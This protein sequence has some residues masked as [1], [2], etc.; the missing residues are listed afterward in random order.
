MAAKHIEL[1]D[2]EMDDFEVCIGSTAP[3]P[4]GAAD[5]DT[6]SEETEESDS[7]DAAP[8]PPRAPG[9]GFGFGAPAAPGGFGFGTAKA[10]AATTT[11][12]VVAKA[13]AAKAATGGAEEACAAFGGMMEQLKMAERE[14]A[15]RED[16]FDSGKHAACIKAM[17]PFADDS[18]AFR[19]LRAARELMSEYCALSPQQWGGWVAQEAR[20]AEALPERRYVVELLGRAVGDFPTPEL[21]IE[22]CAQLNALFEQAEEEDAYSAA[23]RPDGDA[24][25][26][27]WVPALTDA[28][29]APWADSGALKPREVLVR[30]A[31][32]AA[33]AAAGHNF[34][35][36]PAVF[37]AY[38]A[39]VEEEEDAVADEEEDKASPAVVQARA[40]YR[41][42]KA[43]VYKRL[44]LVPH[45]GMDDTEGTLRAWLASDDIASRPAT[46]EA[47]KE[48]LAAARVLN[49]TKPLA[50]QCVPYET[51]LRGTQAKRA[52]LKKKMNDAAAAAAAA[53]KELNPNAKAH[54]DAAVL[55]KQEVKEWVAYIEAEELK[56]DAAR[57]RAVA[58]R[59]VAAVPWSGTLWAKYLRLC[60]DAGDH[61]LAYQLAQRAVRS[62][63]RSLT[64]WIAL[65]RSVECARGLSFAT[66]AMPCFARALR[67]TFRAAVESRHLLLEYLSAARRAALIDPALLPDV[68]AETQRILRHA[69]DSA[70]AQKARQQHAALHDAGGAKASAALAHDLTADPAGLQFIARL[71]ATLLAQQHEAEGSKQPAGAVAPL[72]ACYTEALKA[73]SPAASPRLLYVD[74]ADALASAKAAPTKIRDVYE[75]GMAALQE[76]VFPPEEAG[77]LAAAW[78]SFERLHGTHVRVDA[79]RDGHYDAIR[80]HYLQTVPALAADPV[81]AD[82]EAEVDDEGR[83]EDH[84][85]GEDERVSSRKRKRREMD[86]ERKDAKAEYW[87]AHKESLGLAGPQGPQELAAFLWNIPFQCTEEDIKGFLKG[88]EFEGIRLIKGKGGRSKGICYV[89][90]PDEA[91]LETVLKRDKAKLEGRQVRVQRSDPSRSAKGQEE[92]DAQKLQAKRQKKCVLGAVFSTPPPAAAAAGGAPKPAAAAPAAAARGQAFFKNLLSK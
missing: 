8:A 80:K 64:L 73:V 7:E 4:A 13:P 12:T 31:Y 59:G 39:W 34:Q 1:S 24:A 82:A 68:L 92:R 76:G 26:H 43:K 22:L 67:V 30:D 3:A 27:P 45:Y 15:A 74:F 79:V 33:V 28:W 6:A 19:K 72:V 91:T 54:A 37:R 62:L 50:A 10:S 20:K 9:G 17:A 11:T 25:P 85:V 70:K 38:F 29:W 61:E 56:R 2:D 52:A 81:E 44:C 78:L 16:P 63:P 36:G 86:Q 57:Q 14:R 88:I 42:L 21:W 51:T 66:H 23:R 48:L 18:A 5:A 49:M 69:I 55:D 89:D 47:K 41:L 90:L 58:E 83:P 40:A 84:G 53:G 60:S 35:Q 77:A 46:D 87:Q 65:L 32:E 75:K 71:R